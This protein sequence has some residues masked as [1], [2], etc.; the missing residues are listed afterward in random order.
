[1]IT[2]PTPASPH[3]GNLTFSHALHAV[4]GISRSLATVVLGLCTLVSFGAVPAVPAHGATEDA[5][6][7][8][9]VD[10]DENIGEDQTVITSGHVDVGPRVIDGQWQLMARDDTAQ[11]ATWRYFDDIVYH[12]PDDARQPAP[13]DENYS[14]VPAE[15]GQDVYLIPQTEN[16]QVPWLGWNTQDPAAVAQMAR[17]M[18]LRLTG[19]EGPGDFVLFLQNGNF[20]PPQKLWDS[21]TIGE[22]EQEIWADTNTH[23]HANWVF[24]EPGVYLLHAEI[25]VPLTD[26][27]TVTTAGTLRFAVGSQ[28]NPQE[29]F[30][31]QPATTSDGEGQQ[32]AEQSEADGETAAGAHASEEGKGDQ[33]TLIA[34]VVGVV[35]LVLIVTIILTVVRTSRARRQA[36]RQ[37]AEA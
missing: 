8:Q 5:A 9:H 35:V 37:D 26:G 7:E 11:P 14:F 19:V 6:L 28:T 17:G 24:T 30:D 18:T 33:T 31:A 36:E 20:D 23:V 29:A 15:P 27:E 22:E 12:L 2:L 25:D 10:A 34:I 13:E 4:R 16:H 32:A 1:M 3:D 21:T